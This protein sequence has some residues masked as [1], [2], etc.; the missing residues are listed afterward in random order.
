MFQRLWAAA[1]VL[2]VVAVPVVSQNPPARLTPTS[3]R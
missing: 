3:R 2:T 1:A